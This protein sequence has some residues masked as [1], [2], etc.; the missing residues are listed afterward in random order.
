MGRLIVLHAFIGPRL[1]LAFTWIFTDFVD[2]AYDEWIIPLLGFVFLPWTTLVY[3]LVYDGDGVN[4]L[5]WLLVA[6]ALLADLSFTETDFRG[7]PVRTVLPDP[8]GWGAVVLAR[9]DIPTSYHL[10][11]VVDDALQGISHVV[12]GADLA[13]ATA[14]HRTLQAL[15]GL[16]VPRYHHH[17]LIMGQDG[18]KLSKSNGAES[19]Q[20]L[21]EAGVTPQEIRT[22]VSAVAG[23]SLDDQ[24]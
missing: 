17:P 16:P 20:Q 24:R 12:R 1:A 3:A 14:V 7:V 19:L 22:R 9:K 5:G 13:A 6:L 4:V 21:R 23:A 18:R 15:L 10:A 2:R 8:L 11:V